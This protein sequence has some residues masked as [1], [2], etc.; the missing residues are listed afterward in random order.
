M[1]EDIL[2]ASVRV[3]R[4]EGPLRFTTP[5]VAAAAGISVG[6]LYQYFPNKEALV[7][8]L[9]SRAVEAAWVEAQRILDDRRLSPRQKLRRLSRFFFRAESEEAS[10]MGAV[11]KNA[12]LFF[13]EEPE[14]RA[15]IGRV[16]RRLTA[17]VREALPAGSP[18]RGAAFGA[19]LLMTVLE[20]VGK[21]VA[22]QRLSARAVDR[23]ASACADMLADF[24]GFD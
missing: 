14:Q 18:R 23:W 24:L 3:F 10:T 12:E 9:H 8:A 21:S 19:G 2:A 5:R 15:M 1:R 4:R 16:I 11:L 6:S 20:S 7:F 17:F 13:E 22:G